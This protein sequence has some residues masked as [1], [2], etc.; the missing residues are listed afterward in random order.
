MDIIPMDA[1]PTNGV[2]LKGISESLAFNR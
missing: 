2:A 1:I